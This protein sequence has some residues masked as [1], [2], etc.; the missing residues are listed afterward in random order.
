MNV[1][2]KIITPGADAVNS[3]NDR[4]RLRARRI[5]GYFIEAADEIIQQEGI[6]AITIRKVADNAG[7]TSATLYNYFDNLNH[8]IF[9]AT[10][11]HL[12]EYH[13]EVELRVKSCKTP[14]EIYLVISECFCEHSFRKPEIYDLLFYNNQDGKVEEYTRQ[15]YELF[16]S[17]KKDIPPTLSK[18]IGINNLYRRSFIIV[19]DCVSGGYFTSQNAEDFNEIAM[20]LYRSILKD[21]LAGKLNAVSAVAKTMRYYRQLMGFYIEPEYRKMLIP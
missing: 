4:A 11:K 2:K 1:D 3:P 9:L 18:V 16:E 5:I 8:L 7:Y 14:V 17:E 20:L 13:D 10:M 6:S 21:V 19:M 15:Y 12:E